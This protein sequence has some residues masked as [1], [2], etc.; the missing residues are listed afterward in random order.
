MANRYFIC[1]RHG[2]PVEFDIAQD[3]PVREAEIAYFIRGFRLLEATHGFDGYVV[4][5]A[6]SSE[7]PLP[8]LGD[9]VVALIYGDE[10]CRIPGYAGRVGAVMKCHGLFPTFVPRRRP[11]RLAQ[12]ELAEFLRNLALWLPTGWRWAFSRKVRA[13]CHLLPL[14]YGIPSDVPAVE[15]ARRRYLSSFLG[16]VAAVPKRQALRAV[17]GTPKSYN[18]TRLIEVL[19]E[20]EDRY[21]AGR[22]RVSLTSGFQESLLQEQVYAEVMADTQVCVAPR[23]TTHETWRVFDGLKAGCVVV[24]DKLPPHPFYRDSP[25]LKIEDWRD[26]PALL[27]ALAQDPAKLQALHQESLRFWHKEL[28][29]ERLARRYAAALGLRPKA[30]PAASEG[31][32][33]GRAAAPARAMPT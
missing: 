28:S 8:H 33:E 27:D 30:R 2:A 10:H 6:W 29:E 12:I 14:G 13:R 17:V 25:I 1:P 3:R 18:R 16:S 5:F 23:G 22:I 20:I 24:A 26:L 11:L 9:N 21:G 32:V 15:F 7:T 19:R 31:G 4:C